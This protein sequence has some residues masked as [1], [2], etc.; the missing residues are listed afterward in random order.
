[1]KKAKDKS[2]KNH[3]R[4]DAEKLL[5]KQ[6]EK[7]DINLAEADLRKLLHEI[8]VHQIEL[9][10]QNDE[11]IAA[12]E[13]AQLLKEKYIELYDFAPIG[14]FTLSK[15]GS[16]LELNLRGAKLLG[17]N[18]LRL[19]KS[20]FS[21]FV[22]NN[23]R[24]AFFE[25]LEKVTIGNIRETCEVIL[26]TNGKESFYVLLSC[27]LTENEGRYLLTATDITK[28]KQISDAL[29]ESE[30]R[31]KLAMKA[32]NDGLFDWNLE[33]NEIYYSPG[34][35]KMIGYEDDELPNDFSVWEKTTDPEDV[36]LSL[37][38]QQK[39]ITRQID[40]FVM[41]FKMKH[42]DGHWVDILS[43]AEAIFNDEGK[44][45]R[46]V[47]THTDIT[48]RKVAEKE[49]I[50]AKDKAE[51]SDRLK[52]AFLAN[53]S[54]EIR[55]PMNGILGF[56][57][58]LKEPKLTGEEKQKYISIIEKSGKRMLNIINDL[59][60][61]SKVESGLM[62]L[63]I[64][65]TNINDQIQYIY[66]FFKQEVELK[67]LQI[68]FNKQLPVEHAN[69]TT[70]REKLFA[71]LTNL[72]KNA[73]KYSDEGT[74]ELGCEKKGDFLE[75]FVKDTGIGI[76]K[77]R[78][79]AIFERFVQAD[80]ADKRAFQGAGLG[81]TITKAYVEMLG[82]S[83][84]VQSVEG[85]GSEFYFTLPYHAVPETIESVMEI[86][87]DAESG[88]K[89]SLKVLVAEDDDTSEL[90][91]KVTINDF[92]KQ[93]IFVHNGKD[94]VVA[95]QENPDIDLVLMDIKMPIMSGYEAVKRI[96][97]FNEKVIIIAQTAHGLKGDMEIAIAA[98]C[99]DY[100]SKPISKPLL[101]SIINKYF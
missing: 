96:R 37:E 13:E 33:T 14:Y 52:S 79:S 46:M 83:I 93:I 18:R 97:K 11:L 70:D 91:L 58:L 45:V 89:K 66:A 48:K 74:I 87:D 20:D 54:H 36:K 55:T 84:W 43:K 6:F 101:V 40:R 31:F 5:K 98:G 78:Q 100:I 7:N 56:A 27:T 35:K 28:R 53:M 77:D 29:Q 68:I 82:G 75:F 34:W 2:E 38:Q 41:E 94:A 8:E 1:M 76:P 88:R 63:L 16:I 99:N 19:T 72:V 21:L 15:D 65:K 85:E 3:L 81:L 32:A 49:L 17:K 9:E 73:I 95:C 10:L 64:S 44:A 39:L 92:C 62:K 90:L 4:E 25:M 61:I 26:E 24:P 59:V 23:T 51:E 42:K 86:S 12:R 22:S 47:G 80:I 60:D 69:I 50:F 57:G 67:G 71:I 30:E